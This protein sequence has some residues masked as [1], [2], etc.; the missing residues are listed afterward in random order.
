M[1]GE[2]KRFSAYGATVELPGSVEEDQRAWGMVVFSVPYEG[3]HS[4]CGSDREN[5][6]IDQ[7]KLGVISAPPRYVVEYWNIVLLDWQK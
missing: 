4:W 5:Y 3:I 1:T 6:P 2:D 7:G